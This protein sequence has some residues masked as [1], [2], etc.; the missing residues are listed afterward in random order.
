MPKRNP[1]Q[2]R[3]PDIPDNHHVARHCNPQ[4]IILS[5]DTDAIEGV[6]PSAFELR[7]ELKEQYLSTHWMEFFGAD[8]ETQ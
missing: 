2:K 7:I 3:R 1:K 4:R 5:L 8:I 6:F